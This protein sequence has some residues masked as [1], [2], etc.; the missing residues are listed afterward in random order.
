MRIRLI[1]L[2]VL[3]YGFIG[4]SQAQN[5]LT[6]QQLLQADFVISA[7]IENFPVQKLP[8]TSYQAFLATKHEGITYTIYL[9]F[10]TNEANYIQSS[11]LEIEEEE[12]YACSA[13]YVHYMDG[14]LELK[15]QWMRGITFLT[16]IKLHDNQLNY[17]ENIMYDINEDTYQQAEKAKAADSPVAY[18]QAYL[19][20]QYYDDLEYRIAESIEWGHQKALKAY[21]AKN[22]SLA[23]N[24]MLQLEENCAWLM[25]IEEILEDHFITI[26]SDVTLFYLKAGKYQDCIALSKRI[27]QHYP[28]ATSVYLQY[29]DALFKLKNT[30]EASKIYQQ[31]TLQM[32]QKGLSDKIPSR[33]K[34][35]S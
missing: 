19:S 7:A 25:P 18:C 27:L 20:M 16:K 3:F 23:A 30:K 12:F 17:H 10:T 34:K 4:H 31:Y 15:C 29:G 28:D 33:V 35:R 13:P 2:G 21:Q 8:D 11:S 5:I 1:I 22:Y 6:A 32:E 24:I 14:M 9:L 26:W